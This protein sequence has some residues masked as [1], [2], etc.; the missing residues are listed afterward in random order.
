MGPDDLYRLPPG[1]FTAARNALAKTL[2]GDAAR[3][4]R[5][6]KKPNAVAWS[7]NQLYFKA[8]PVWDALMKAGDALRDA[9][10]AALQGRKPDVRAA[11]EKHREAL[12]RAVKRAED[13]ARL[14]KVHPNADPLARMLDALSLASGTREDAGRFT[15][16]IQP[17]G[18]DALA[19]VK[20]APPRPPTLREVAKKEKAK[21][22]EKARRQ[23]EARVDAATT[24]LDRAR[25]KADAA[26]R[27]LNRADADVTDAERELSDAERAVEAAQ[28]A[29]DRIG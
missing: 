23:A 17:S 6:L 14:M 15:D 28:A 3:E 16:L 29:L 24:A 21:E 18:F 12:S 8:R 19:G 4:V 27:A 2:S 10:L 9:Q 20:P 22:A 11:T 7:V 26:R 5:A 25:K 13:L 1:Q